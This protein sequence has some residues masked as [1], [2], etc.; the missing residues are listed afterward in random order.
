MTADTFLRPIHVTHSFFR[1]HDLS[2]DFNK[3][4]RTSA[5]GTTGISY[6]FGT[7][8]TGVR[9]VQSSVLCLEYLFMYCPL[10]EAELV[11]I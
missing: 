8:F 6:P 2:L 9:V 10:W 7:I 3:N 5:T 4:N 1:F 11:E